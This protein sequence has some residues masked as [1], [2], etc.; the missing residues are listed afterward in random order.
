MKKRLLVI[1]LLTIMLITLLFTHFSK[2]KNNKTNTITVAEVTHSVF[3]APWYVALNKG[4]FE[5]EGLNI[6]VILTPGADKVMAS[7][8]SGDAQIGLSGPEATIY[9]KEKSNDD[10]IINFAALTKRDGQF[11][12]GDCKYKDN[13]SLKDLYNKEI[14][15]GRTGGMPAMVFNYALNKEKINSNNIIINYSVE[16][17]N[18]TSAYISGMA[19]FVNLFEPNATKLEKE[20]YGCVL[21]SIGTLAG[22]VPYT[23]FNT[24]LSYYNNNEEIIKKFT[25]AINKGLD[26]V[27]N[28]ES[29]LI[30]ETIQESFKDNTIEELNEMI[31]RYKE[32]DSWWDNTFIKESSFTRLEE[33]MEYNG[34]INSKDNFKYLVKNNYNE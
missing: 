20:K 12:F 25:K 13:F 5:E 1:F 16:F 30:A 2:N 27:L 17:A 34:V 21:Q 4:Y 11:I 26:F 10:Y 3:Y 15:V 33:I 28:N 9:I 24:R 18:L 8:L 6:E 19:P 29:L 7:V 22:E 32:A 31:K 23:A 14:L